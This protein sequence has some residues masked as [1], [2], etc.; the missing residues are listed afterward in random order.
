MIRYCAWCHRAW[1]AS[2]IA[3]P[4]DEPYLCPMCEDKEPVLRRLR[5]TDGDSRDAAAK[6]EP[7]TALQRCGRQGHTE[8]RQM[9]LTV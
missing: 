7:P 1:E 5:E 3:P 8:V 4:L 6:E 2:K 9:T